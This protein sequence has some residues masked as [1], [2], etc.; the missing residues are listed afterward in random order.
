MFICHFFPKLRVGTCYLSQDILTLG[1]SRW[2]FWPNDLFFGSF[3]VIWGHIRFCLQL[4]ID[5]ALGMVPMCFTRTDASTDM[6]YDLLGYTR[7]LTWHWPEVKFWHWP[8]KVN[9]YTFRSASTRGTWCCQNYVTIF[10]SS[11]VIREKH[12]FTKKK[13]S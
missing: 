10:L 13:H 9:M 2:S 4:L 5:R 7:D 12:F 3:E 8:L 6:Q 11:K 1:H